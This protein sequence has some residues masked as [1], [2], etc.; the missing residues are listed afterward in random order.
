MARGCGGGV[1]CLCYTYV[2]G[3]N[4]S[5]LYICPFYTYAYFI[6]MSI[7]LYYTYAYV[8]RTSMLLCMH[9]YGSSNNEP[10]KCTDLIAGF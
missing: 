10:S 4:M 7:L 5:I 6:H 8:I 9:V 3:T 2:Y 1:G